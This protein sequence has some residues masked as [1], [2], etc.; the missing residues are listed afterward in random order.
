MKTYQY[1]LKRIG[2]YGSV[3]EVH[4]PIAQV[5]G[6]PHVKAQEIAIFEDG[7]LGEVFTLDKDQ[8]EILLFSKDP[9]KIGTQ[10]T[11][12][13]TTIS[14]PVGKNLLGQ[15][16]NPLGE[17][18]FAERKIEGLKD[19]VELDHEVKGIA[20]RKRIRRPFSTGISLVD[21]LLPLGKGQRQLVIG[22]RKTGKSSFLLSVIKNQILENALVIYAAI[23]KKKSDIKRLQEFFQKEGL[24][25]STLIVASDASDS[26]SLIYITPYTAISIAE[27]FKDLGT[28][29]LVI[30]DDLSTHAK[31]YRE[32][33]LLGG[34]FPG[35][36]SYPGDIFHIHARLLERAGN[37]KH[38]VKG[39]ASITALPVVETIEGDLTG[40]ISTN[41]MGMTD[42]HIFFDSDAY[43]KGR[44]PAIN[45]S[46]SVTRV[47]RQTQTPL[48]REINRE[49]TAFLTNYE[50]MLTYSHFGAELS[51]KVK[52]ILKTG[53]KLQIFFDQHYKL[54]VPEE[55]QIIL[56]SL[57]WL[58]TLNEL[59][60]EAVDTLRTRLIELYQDEEKKKMLKDITR[61]DTFHDLLLKVAKKKEELL[62]LINVQSQSSNV[63]STTKI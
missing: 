48:K 32:V 51:D 29:V 15:I 43:Y 9:V 20:D 39:E 49:I 34:R 46:L 11:R 22:D 57:I 1:Y 18:F 50:K 45:V 36:D 40:F 6:L 13:N 27:Y 56:L 52:T 24:L 55:V 58:N 8:I 16:I 42:G 44:R 2:E 61:S 14:V 21:L 54:I 30:F 28:D 3:R 4:Y 41:I 10:V 7:K 17:S 59:A 19:S 35:R 62:S 31:F 5:V 23:G 60:N 47:G 53:Q 25:A 37:F 33:A 38:D 26:P 12:T 63:K